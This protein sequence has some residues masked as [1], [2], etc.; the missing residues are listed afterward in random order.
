MKIIIAAAGRGTRMQD[1]TK[2]QPKHLIKVA[3]KPFLFYLLENIKQAGYSEI[4]V[5]GGYLIEKIEDFLNT[6][7]KNIKLINQHEA[8]QKGY[9]GT[10]CPVNSAKE[11]IGQENFIFIPGDNLYSPEDL[12]KFSGLEDDYNYLG[13]AIHPQP[14]YYGVVKKQG[15]YLENIIEKPVEYISDLIN[16][17]LYKFTP[18]IFTKLEQI[19]I[20]PRGEYELTDAINLLAKEKKVKVVQLQDYWYDFGK[21]EDIIK[22][23][24]F[25]KK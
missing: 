8:I 9:Y 22:I 1:L 11:I 25:L 12:K 5:I 6:Y 7:D 16:T 20:S 15:E 21:P 4:I 18:E 14:Q 24:E 3:G 10:A 17:G 2:D 23:E 13:A 19:K